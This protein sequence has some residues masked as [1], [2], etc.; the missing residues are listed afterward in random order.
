M[1]Q[2]GEADP[3]RV[4]FTYSPRGQ[5]TT[6]TR[7]ADLAGN[8]KVGSTRRL[9]NAQGQLTDLTH[10]NALD[11]VL[12]DF[13]YQY[14][15]LFQLTEESGTFG[16][17]QYGYDH[18]G[19]LVSVDKEAVRSESYQYDANGNRVGARMVVGPGNQILADG[20]FRYAYD[21]EGNLLGTFGP[22]GTSVFGWW[23]TQDSFFQQNYCNQFA[24]VMA[25]EIVSG[26]AE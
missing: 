2:G 22:D 24:V 8:Q 4:D 21:N 15:A 18:A 26:T 6:E 19:Q 25:Q 1:L 20:T 23:V 13:D 5:K 11:A 12:V 7:F 3:M 16:P 17:K 10:F 14:D 9:Y